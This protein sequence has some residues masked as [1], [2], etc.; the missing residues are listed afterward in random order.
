MGPFF[1]NMTYASLKDLFGANMTNGNL[2]FGVK[3]NL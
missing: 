1:V 3:F 2:F